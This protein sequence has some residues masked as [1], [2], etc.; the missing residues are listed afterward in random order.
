MSSL[1]RGPGTL[2]SALV[3]FLGSSCLGE[4]VDYAKLSLEELMN[5]QVTMNT[6]TS[7]DRF[8]IPAAVTHIDRSL[9]DQA[10]ARNLND[11]LGI[12]VPNMEFADHTALG[13]TS[14]ATSKMSLAT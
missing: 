8:L 2:G 3:L 10:N 14:R 11:L 12:Y 5:V 6:L 4:E 13:L 1:K 7:T 9:I